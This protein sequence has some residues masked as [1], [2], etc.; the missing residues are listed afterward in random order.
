MSIFPKVPPYKPLIGVS[1]SQDGR[2]RFARSGH[3][4]PT[5]EEYALIEAMWPDYSVE[6]IARRLGWWHTGRK[7]YHT[8]AVWNAKRTIDNLKREAEK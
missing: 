3:G 7:D 6:H 4:V 1:S 2:S 5:S 8:R